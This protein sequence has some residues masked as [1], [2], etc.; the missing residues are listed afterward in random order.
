MS[1]DRIQVRTRFGQIL[2]LLVGRALAEVRLSHRFD[3]QYDEDAIKLD[4]SIPDVDTPRVI[5][6]V[7]QTEA[8]NVLQRKLLRYF[9]QV[10][11]AKVHFGSDVKMISLIFGLPNRD[12]PAS[13][14]SSSLSFFD[15]AF[16]PRTDSFFS[17]EK[18][19][20]LELLEEVALGHAKAGPA[21]EDSIDSICESCPEGVALLGD[22]IKDGINS[23]DA[24][25]LLGEMW[26]MERERVDKLFL[27]DELTPI[28]S[29]HKRDLLKNLFYPEARFRELVD[30]FSNPQSK[31]SGTLRLSKGNHPECLIALEELG[32]CE[33]QATIG[34]IRFTLDKAI[35][36]VIRDSKKSQTVAVLRKS[37]ARSEMKWFFEDVHDE[38]R[39]QRMAEVYLETAALGEAAM[40]KAIYENL[41]QEIFQNIEHCRCWMADLMVIHLDTSQNILNNIISAKPDYVIQTGKP[42]NDITMK[43]ARIMSSD[44]S[45]RLHAKLASEVWHELPKKTFPAKVMAEKLKEAR[46]NGAMYLQKFNPFYLVIE[47]I[48]NEEGWSFEY[49]GTP[50]IM[51]D[52]LQNPQVGRFKAYFGEKEGR[53]V[54]ING[55]QIRD[56][57]KPKE[58]AARGRAL[59]YRI[60]D[61]GESDAR[62]IR[63]LEDTQFVFV[64]DGDVSV[65]MRRQLEWAGWKTCGLEELPHILE[66]IY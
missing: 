8:R 20:K 48:L 42:F 46:I 24:N 44:S 33:R 64:L 28:I 16:L 57:H 2:E 45:M 52:L 35:G 23:A 32:L 6:E 66:S 11:Q 51:G 13:T 7:T 59:R 53:R 27:P 62:V 36:E 34:G 31:A 10:A 50:T 14:L 4:Y 41:S 60:E 18:H 1:N 39:R 19:V 55:L 56:A 12:L 3:W 40:E 9:E 49:K 29:D 25:C 38:S 47:S 21:D 5:I 30:L 43:F 61:F 54:V 22:Y 26:D 15:A 65:K 63:Q 17:Q 58:W 37:L